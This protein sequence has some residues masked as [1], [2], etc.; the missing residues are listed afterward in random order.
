[1]MNN[2]ECMM[3]TTECMMNNNECMMNNTEFKMNNTECKSN[4]LKYL[5]LFGLN[6]YLIVLAKYIGSM[7][8]CIMGIHTLTSV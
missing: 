7:Y 6:L 4:S 8:I 1:M 2:T 5:V 3:N